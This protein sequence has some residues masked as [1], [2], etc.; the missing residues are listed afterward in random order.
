MKAMAMAM[1]TI[2]TID[3][4][5]QWDGMVTDPALPLEF[6]NVQRTCLET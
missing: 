3:S 4:K 2:I 6:L 1:A 5:R